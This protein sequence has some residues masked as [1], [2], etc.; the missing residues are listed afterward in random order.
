[1]NMRVGV[2]KTLGL[3][4]LRKSMLAGPRA[5]HW[6]ERGG[7]IAPATQPKAPIPAMGILSGATFRGWFRCA[8]RRRF[9][10][11]LLFAKA[12]LMHL[13]RRGMQMPSDCL[14]RAEAKSG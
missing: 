6:L 3:T 11:N 14:D 13:D 9:G 10:L 1:M 5:R 4:F 7:R 12:G 8:I 2:R